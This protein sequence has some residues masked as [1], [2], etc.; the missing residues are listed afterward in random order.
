MTGF[1]EDSGSL[2]SKQHLQ[3]ALCSCDH[4]GLSGYLLVA[5]EEDAPDVPR[6]FRR[7]LGIGGT[8]VP[9]ACCLDPSLT[10]LPR[11]C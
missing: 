4:E 6:I 10:F 7:T 5:V 11:L 1:K 8:R 3:K 9:E 2:K